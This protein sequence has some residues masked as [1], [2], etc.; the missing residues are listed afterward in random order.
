MEKK[1]VFE[2]INSIYVGMGFFFLTIALI[3]IMIPI[4]PYIWYRLNPKETDK[5]VEKIVKEITPPEVDIEKK[6]EII[7]EAISNLPP[8]DPSLPEGLFVIIPKIGVESPISTS[9]D[10]NDGLE[11]GSWIVSNY[12]TPEKTELPII[13]AAHRFGYSY[14]GIEKRNKISYYNLPKTEEGDEIIIYWNQRAYKYRIYKSEESTYI[15]DYDTDLILYTCKFFN[16]PIR[17][18]RYAKRVY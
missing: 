10:Y 14:W 12:G 13:L 2:K 15:S 1:T 8:F 5:D 16:S 17:I 3:A 11:N 6:E 18:F 7:E 9:K 4:W